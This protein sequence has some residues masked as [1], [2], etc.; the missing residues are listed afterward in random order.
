MR[1]RREYLG[2]HAVVDVMLVVEYALLCLLLRKKDLP[3]RFLV[4]APFGQQQE[5]VCGILIFHNNPL[6]IKPF[7]PCD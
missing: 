2:R 6:H 5:L 4:L 1:W 3:L 7:A